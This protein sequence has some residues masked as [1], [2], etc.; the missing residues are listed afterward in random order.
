MLVILDWQ[1]QGKPPP[2]HRDRGASSEICGVRIHEVDLTRAYIDVAAQALRA[3][4]HQ[5]EILTEGW[6]SNRHA[7]AGALSHKG[8]R[9][10]AYVACHINA[11]GGRYA[12]SFYDSRSAGGSRLSACVASALGEQLPELSASKTRPCGPDQSPRAWSVIRGIWAAPAWCSAICFEPAF[13]DH[14][15][16]R[17]LLTPEGLARIGHALAD[18]VMTWATPQETT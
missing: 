6:Y 4:G 12:A 16:H 9:P 5:V 15:A 2:K 13:I 14:A 11:G 18:G 7:Q 8:E 3:A 10:A 1:H 17:P